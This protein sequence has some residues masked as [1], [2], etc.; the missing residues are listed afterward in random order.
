MIKL[1]PDSSGNLCIQK[2]SGQLRM[3]P[4]SI[5]GKV[6]D[7]PTEYGYTFEGWMYRLADQGSILTPEAKIGPSLSLSLSQPS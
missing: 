6:A 3:I 2:N 7:V 5:T 1:R 4:T